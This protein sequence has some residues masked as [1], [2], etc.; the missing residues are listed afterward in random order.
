MAP[1][2]REIVERRCYETGGSRVFE[3][4]RDQ[5]ELLWSIPS[6]KGYLELV[7]YHAEVH[8]TKTISAN[9]NYDPS[10]FE[11]GKVPM[12]Q[13]LQDLL[14]AYKLGVKTLYY[15]KHPPR[16]A[17]DSQTDMPAELRKKLAEKESYAKRS[18]R[19]SKKTTDCAG[20]AC[21]I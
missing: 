4:L 18:L 14:Y 11:S 13:L 8:W 19:L 16:G 1:C 9:T 2:Q 6:N 12:K 17:S 15:H 3:R 10:R 5:Y 7:W 20:G 21:K